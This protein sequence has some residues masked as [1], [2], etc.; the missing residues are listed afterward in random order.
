MYDTPDKKL[1][2]YCIRYGTLIVIVGGGGPKNVKKLQQNSK[3][4]D[5]NYLLRDLSELITKRLKDGEICYSN[6]GMDFKGNLEF[7]NE[8]YE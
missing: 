4:K 5:E 7:D 3:L 8:D 2:L 1:R 6:S